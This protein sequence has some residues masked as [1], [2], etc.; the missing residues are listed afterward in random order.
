[1]NMVC[2][3]A[4][5][6]FVC[7]IRYTIVELFATWYADDLSGTVAEGKSFADLYKSVF[8]FSSLFLQYPMV[9]TVVMITMVQRG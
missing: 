5:M 2:I 7:L 4:L 9:T 1:M 3:V 6:G 8:Q